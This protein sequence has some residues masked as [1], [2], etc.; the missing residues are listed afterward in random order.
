[1]AGGSFQGKVSTSL[2]LSNHSDDANSNGAVAGVAGPQGGGGGRKQQ[3]RRTCFSVELKQ[4]EFSQSRFLEIIVHR[5]P[6]RVALD[7]DP[8]P[9]RVQPQACRAP[10]DCQTPAIT[11]SSTKRSPAGPVS[12]GSLPSDVGA[13]PSQSAQCLFTVLQR[14]KLSCVNV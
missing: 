4:A 8:G 14:K 2:S 10:S 6:A 3:D 11:G 5:A 1:M 13:F 12:L 7:E 9:Q